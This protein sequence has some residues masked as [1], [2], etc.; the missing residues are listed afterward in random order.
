M[1][2]QQKIKLIKNGSIVCRGALSCVNI[3]TQRPNS[4]FRDDQ[5][6]YLT[7][8][9]FSKYLTTSSSLADLHEKGSAFPAILP[10][11]TTL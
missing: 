11:P 10:K 9:K 8:F 3:I 6:L 7:S 4:K 5:I 1:L 2:N